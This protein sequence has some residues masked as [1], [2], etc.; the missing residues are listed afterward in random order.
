MSYKSDYLYND[1]NGGVVVK[2][3]QQGE[4]RGFCSWFV[5]VGDCFIIL[6]SAF[7]FCSRARLVSGALPNVGDFLQKNGSALR[8]AC[9]R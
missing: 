7:Y 3:F 9:E 6:S 1:R 8:I 2:S 5:V 4:F